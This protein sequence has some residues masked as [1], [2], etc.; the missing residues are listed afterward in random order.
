M[1]GGGDDGVMACV[2]NFGGPEQGDVRKFHRNTPPIVFR[3]LEHR[4]RNGVSILFAR[5]LPVVHTIT[6]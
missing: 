2:L 3:P 4:P 1:N 5:D 6:T